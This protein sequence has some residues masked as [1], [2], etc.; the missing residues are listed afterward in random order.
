MEGGLILS[1]PT[2]ILNLPF[3]RGPSRSY[4]LPGGLKNAAVRSPNTSEW[5]AAE[6][7]RH[8]AE[9]IVERPG[10]E[11]SAR[12]CVS[13]FVIFYR[14]LIRHVI[15]ERVP[16]VIDGRRRACWRDL[17]KRWIDGWMNGWASR[18]LSYYN[19]CVRDHV[20]LC[21]FPSAARD[22]QM[23]TC[24]FS[25]NADRVIIKRLENCYDSN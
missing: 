2:S 15:D 23:F 3:V 12:R 7:R 22:Q 10:V 5:I 8:P 25:L 19:V 11:W 24:A 21:V 14:S 20:S 1:L 16:R 17:W 6:D 4:S 9:R 13:S 18:G